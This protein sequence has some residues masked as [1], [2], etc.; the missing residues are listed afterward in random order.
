MIAEVGNGSFSVV[1]SGEPVYI[2]EQAGHAEVNWQPVVGENRMV[3]VYAPTAEEIRESVPSAAGVAPSQY[4]APQQGGFVPSS[5]PVFASVEEARPAGGVVAPST[6]GTCGA[7]G[8]D[9][10][11]GTTGDKSKT[12]AA[13]TTGDKSKSSTSSSSKKKKGAKSLMALGA[14]VTTPLFSIL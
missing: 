6:S 2:T 3:P 5:T 12:G 7:K 4:I 13:G 1:T 14:V 10:A 8:T 9:A 11:A